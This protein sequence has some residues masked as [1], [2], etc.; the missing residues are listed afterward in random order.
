[1][2]F[3]KPF[4]L[5]TLFAFSAVSAIAIPRNVH[6]NNVA[7]TEITV[8]Q[9]TTVL[10]DLGTDVAA[11][12]AKL[13]EFP[14]AVI[15]TVE[16]TRFPDVFVTGDINVDDLSDIVVDLNAVISGAVA[17]LEALV[18][19]NVAVEVGGSAEV[20]VDDIAKLLAEILNVREHVLPATH[21]ADSRVSARVHGTWSDSKPDGQSRCRCPAT[22]P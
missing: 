1:M 3:L 15:S 11:P 4:T 16:M 19:A 18:N 22:P 20:T 17:Q 7:R 8:T 6:E 5:F 2:L 10:A 21:D 12:V 9:L 14:V 13:S